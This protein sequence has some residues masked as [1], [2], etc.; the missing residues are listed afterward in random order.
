MPHNVNT[1]EGCRRTVASILILETG[2]AARLPSQGGR[3]LQGIRRLRGGSQKPSGSV[4]RRGDIAEGRAAGSLEAVVAPQEVIVERGQRPSPR[5]QG[6]LQ[7]RQERETK[8]IYDSGT[9]SSS[10]PNGVLVPQYVSDP[11]VQRRPPSRRAAA[12]YSATDQADAAVSRAQAAVERA[13]AAK[14][15]NEAK[16]A[17]DPDSGV[18]WLPALRQT[19]AAASHDAA[20]EISDRIADHAERVLGNS[21]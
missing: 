6:A 13:D 19:S 5:H 3:S 2:A 10:R 14:C 20:S 9:T 21:D 15:S 17:V 8:S 4:P 11:V 16:A 12:H 18:L 7:Q 1:A